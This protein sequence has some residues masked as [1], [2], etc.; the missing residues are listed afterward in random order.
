MNYEYDIL[1][2]LNKLIELE[3]MQIP[4]GTRTHMLTISGTEMKNEALGVP[5]MAFT[6]INDGPD[7]VYISINDTANIVNEDPIKIN[8]TYSVDLKYPIINSVY[9]KAVDGGTATV[10]FRGV[11]GRKL[12]KDYYDD[13]Y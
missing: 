9:V 2:A 10:R 11:Y 8:E 3:K 1:M 7:S 4:F 6:M 12:G 5:W 13:R